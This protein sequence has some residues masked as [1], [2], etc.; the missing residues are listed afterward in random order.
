[1]KIL[2]KV[3]AAVLVV[4]ALAALTVGILLKPGKKKEEDA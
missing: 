1:M 3:V 2:K 4:G